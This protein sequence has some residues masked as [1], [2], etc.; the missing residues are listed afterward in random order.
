MIGVI[1]GTLPAHVRGGRFPQG[2]Y[3]SIRA[4]QPEDELLLQTRFSASGCHMSDNH[5][6]PHRQARIRR[7][8]ERETR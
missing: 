7:T 4:L 6:S 8:I 3:G 1:K 5:K 2:R